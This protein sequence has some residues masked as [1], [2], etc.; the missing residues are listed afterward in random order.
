[1][2]GF[3][4][5][6]DFKASKVQKGGYNRAS[7]FGILTLLGSHLL[8]MCPTRSSRGHLFHKEFPLG[9]R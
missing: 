4:A 5:R 8:Q 9:A 3:K 2:S 1:M 7:L 6:R